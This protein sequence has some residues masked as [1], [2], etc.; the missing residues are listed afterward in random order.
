VKFTERVRVLEEDRFKI[1][2][3]KGSIRYY[4]KPDMNKLSFFTLSF[5]LLAAKTVKADDSMHLS[6]RRHKSRL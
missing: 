5:V 4:G 6:S 3:Q 2:K 1:M